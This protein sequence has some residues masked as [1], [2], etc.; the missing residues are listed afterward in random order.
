MKKPARIEVFRPAVEQLYPVGHIIVFGVEG[1]SGMIVA[2]FKPAKRPT[3]VGYL[4]EPVA[5][6]ETA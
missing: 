6:V 4:V 5:E 1:V 3:E 2:R